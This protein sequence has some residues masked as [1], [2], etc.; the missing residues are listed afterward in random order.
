MLNWQNIKVGL[1]KFFHQ[2]NKSLYKSMEHAYACS[3]SVVIFFIMIIFIIVMFDTKNLE[4]PV[5]C[6]AV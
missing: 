1:L 4:R 2:E 5:N 6:R 3:Y